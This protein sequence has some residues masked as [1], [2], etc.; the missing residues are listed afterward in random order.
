MKTRR[1]IF[2]LLL[3]VLGVVLLYNVFIA[4]YLMQFN[5]I[6]GMGMHSMMQ[7]NYYID[8]QYIAILLIIIAGLLFMELAV[9]KASENRCRLC[10]Y[11]IE[12]EKWRVCPQCGEHIRKGKGQ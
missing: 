9:F 3:T 12:N 6:M 5:Y 11:K 8:V 2:F 1:T 4:P 10:G 7:N